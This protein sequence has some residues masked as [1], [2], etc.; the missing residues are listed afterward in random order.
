MKNYDSQPVM[1]CKRQWQEPNQ[2][3]SL[4]VLYMYLLKNVA[5]QQHFVN[6]IKY[7]KSKWNG[8]Q[9]NSL[10]LMM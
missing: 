8:K 10:P 2:K 4:F 9:L 6:M 1:N 7:D 3:E 5:V